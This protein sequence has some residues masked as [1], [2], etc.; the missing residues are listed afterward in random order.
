MIRIAMTRCAVLPLGG[1]D[2][3][4]GANQACLWQTGYPL[5]TGFGGGSPS[6]D[7]HRHDARR[8][9]D[10]GEADA[11]VWISAFRPLPAPR[12]DGLPTIALT[13]TA[14]ATD[15]VIPVGTPGIDHEGQVFRS[16]GLV[17]IG[18]AALRDGPPSVA[19][20]IGRID[21]ALRQGD[22]P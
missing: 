2:N 13:A 6:Q 15:V 8:L 22:Q 4:L 16:D 14:D 12:R 21:H 11:L 20:I 5:R 3:L 9:I 17:A 7:P 19:E 18:L 10:S 1:S